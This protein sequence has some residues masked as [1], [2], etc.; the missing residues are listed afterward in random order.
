LIHIPDSRA[1][2]IGFVIGSSTYGI[3]L[4]LLHRLCLTDLMPFQI[5]NWKKIL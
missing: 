1:I 5:M 4:V 3:L 2:F